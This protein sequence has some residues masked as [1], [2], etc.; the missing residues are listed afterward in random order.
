MD[1]RNGIWKNRENTR[2]GTHIPKMVYE[3]NRKIPEM[4][5]INYRIKPEQQAEKQIIME[6]KMAKQKH[7]RL[8]DDILEIINNRDKEMYP[9]ENVYITEAVR[10]FFKKEEAENVMDELEDIQDKLDRIEKIL[11]DNAMKKNTF[12]DSAEKKELLGKPDYF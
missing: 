4:V 5:Y 1:T 12:S 11:E 10:N 7:F 8:P 6:G 3:K 9:T 2:N